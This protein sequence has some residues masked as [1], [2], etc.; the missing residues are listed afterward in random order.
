MNKKNAEFTRVFKL[1]RYSVLPHTAKY[2][3]YSMGQHCQGADIVI[4]YPPQAIEMY[5]R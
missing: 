2:D 5:V 3:Y 4:V 1:A